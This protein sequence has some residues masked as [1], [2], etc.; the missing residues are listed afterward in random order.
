MFAV[1]WFNPHYAAPAMATFF[2]LL[3]QMLRHMRRWKIKGRAVGIGLTRAV[4]VLIVAT[5]AICIYHAVLDHQTSYGLQWGGPNWQRADIA[6]Q[7]DS[8][9][10]KHLVIV[11][12]TKRRHNSFVEWVY[13]DADIDHSKIVWAREIPGIDIHPLLKYFEDRKVWLVEPDVQPPHIVPFHLDDPVASPA[14]AAQ[15]PLR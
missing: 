12:Y 13:N 1:V 10:G 7:L 6:A 14:L 3:M 4:V 8:T 9:D 15:V 2:C 11:R 5:F